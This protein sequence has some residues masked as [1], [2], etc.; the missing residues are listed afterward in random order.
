MPSTTVAVGSAIGLH[1][2]PAAVIAEAVA[3][4]GVDVT[5]E[6]ADG[7]PVDGGSALMIMTLGATKGTEVTVTADDQA[8]VDK[9]AALVA[10]DLDA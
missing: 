10:S 8:T 4:S 6:V 2:R 1:A 5:L 9:I 7:E 3:D